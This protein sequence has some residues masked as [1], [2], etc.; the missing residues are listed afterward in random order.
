MDG[1]AIRAI[2][3]RPPVR[4][5]ATTRVTMAEHRIGSRDEW[6]EARLKLLEAENQY[7]ASYR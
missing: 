7:D 3:A 5:H 4:D 1:A 6:P 2:V